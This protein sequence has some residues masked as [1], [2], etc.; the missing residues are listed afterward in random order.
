MTKGTGEIESLDF[1]ACGEAGPVEIGRRN[2][3][4]RI[5]EGTHLVIAGRVATHPSQAKRQTELNDPEYSRNRH[6]YNHPNLFF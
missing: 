1:V 6:P 5:L 4:I 2:R 3:G